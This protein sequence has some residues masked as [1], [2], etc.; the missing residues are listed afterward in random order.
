MTK[1]AH[2]LPRR[3]ALLAGAGALSA[4]ALAGRAARA[5]GAAFPEAGKTIRIVS[6]Y[7]A[8]GTTDI[9]ARTIAA[10]M[11]ENWG[12]PVVVENRSGGNGVVGTDFV[13]RAAPDGYTLALGNNQTHATNEVLIPNIPHK[14]AE[15]FAPITLAA[16]ASHALVVPASS[17]A[18]T[19]AELI[20]M[21][22]GGRSLSFASSSIGSASHILSESFRRRN[23]MDAVHVPYRGA[24]PATTDLVAGQV[25][26]MMAT[27]ASVVPLIRDGKLRALGIGGARRR[28]DL[29]DVPT[30][31]ELGH[32][33]VAA[34]AWFGLW[35]PAGTPRPILERLNAEIRRILSVP[36]VVQRLEQVGFEVETMSVDEFTAFSRGEIARWAALI[37][38]AEI[39]LD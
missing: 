21:G 24:A 17:P 30:L 31:R 10:R 29:P 9:L 8:G 18:R 37:R 22:K 32:E 27:A 14:A 1:T 33:Y 2:A 26:F 15:N 19:I 11:Q 28:A 7:P 4:L 20:A 25:Q 3:H 38:E 16:R 23:G 5:Q 12:N 34:D 13:A 36:E 35:A 39:K 6:A